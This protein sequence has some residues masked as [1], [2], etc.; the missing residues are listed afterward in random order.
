MFSRPGTSAKADVKESWVSSFSQSFLLIY[1]CAKSGNL[2]TLTTTNKRASGWLL[3]NSNSGASNVLLD[4][5][6]I[7]TVTT[8]SHL[9]LPD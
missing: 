2:A 6:K 9:S 3:P 4:L 7:L 8:Y 5:R 1:N